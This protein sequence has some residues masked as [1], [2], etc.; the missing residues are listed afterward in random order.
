[1]AALG[2]NFKV[3]KIDACRVA[4]GPGKAGHKAKL[5]R[6]TPDAEYDRKKAV[7]LFA[8]TDLVLRAALWIVPRRRVIG[9]VPN[10]NFVASCTGR[11]AGFS[12]LRMRAI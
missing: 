11:S 10:S 8:A 9:G 7:L 3:E 6:I 1:V 2:S 4:S 12:P 5:D